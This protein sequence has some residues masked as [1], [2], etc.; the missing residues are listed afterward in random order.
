MSA[1]KF[2]AALVTVYRRHSHADVVVGK[3]L[4]GYRYDGSE[5]PDLRLA[6]PYVDQFPP[7]D[8]SRGLANKYGSGP[9]S[10]GRE[11]RGSRPGRHRQPGLHD[12]DRRGR[13]AEAVAP[14]HPP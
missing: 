8:L 2:L 13:Q 3:V 4:E 12:H 7:D 5:R 14:R 11:A 10:A 1:P 6:S 9:L